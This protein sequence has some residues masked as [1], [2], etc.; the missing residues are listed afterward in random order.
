LELIEEA[1]SFVVS[2]EDT[3]NCVGPN[4]TQPEPDLV[5]QLAMEIFAHWLVMVLMLDNVWWIGGIGAWELKQI[6][7]AKGGSRWRKSWKVEE[8]WWPEIMLGINRQLNKY[9]EKA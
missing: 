5:H 2:G 9:R 8:D 1:M 7:T 6:V 4:F 3:G